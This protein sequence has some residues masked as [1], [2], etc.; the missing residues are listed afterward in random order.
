MFELTQM[1]CLADI[2]RLQAHLRP[3]GTAQIFEGRRTTFAEFDQRTNQVARALLEAGASVVGCDPQAAENFGVLC[4]IEI[5]PSAEA[6][7]TGADCAILMTEWPEYAALPPAAFTERMARPLLLD[8]RRA[9]DAAAMR[10]AGV[11]YRAI[12]LG[13]SE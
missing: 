5:A 1:R 2:P 13:G 3:D 9:F 4:D 8:G 11:E 10:N 6:A 12:G 7:L